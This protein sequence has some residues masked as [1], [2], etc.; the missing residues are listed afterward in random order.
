MVNPNTNLMSKA[1]TQILF[2][3]LKTATSNKQ[4]FFFS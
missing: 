1:G 4:F 2:I 3:N